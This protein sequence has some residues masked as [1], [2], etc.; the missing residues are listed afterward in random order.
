MILPCLVL[1][2]VPSLTHHKVRAE[3]LY[4]RLPQLEERLASGLPEA[5]KEY[6]HLNLLVR[7]LRSHFASAI[8]TLPELLEQGR[9]TFDLLWALFP[10][11]SIVYSIDDHSEQP[12]CTIVDFGEE[13]EGMRGKFF[14]LDVRNINFDGK[15]FG[16]V[17]DIVVLWEF[18]GAQSITSVSYS[19]PPE[20]GILCLVTYLEAHASSW[21]LPTPYLLYDA[22]YDL[23]L[24]ML[25]PEPRSAGGIPLTV[26]S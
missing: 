14:A 9:I 17:T 4:H 8:K 10:P 3:V 22:V 21:D 18:A 11:N 24:A 13:R 12:E 2:T 15:V 25:T 26:P 7:F 20:S 23:Q 19:F 1:V 5:D 6:Q 16:D